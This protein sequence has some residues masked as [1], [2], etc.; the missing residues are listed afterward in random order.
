MIHRTVEYDVREL[1][2]GLWLWVIEPAGR[3]FISGMRWH[4]RDKAV[5]ACINEID[6][7]LERTRSRR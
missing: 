6:D 1:E 2:P 7:G 3:Q 5:E 4:S